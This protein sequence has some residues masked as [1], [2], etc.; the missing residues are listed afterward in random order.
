MKSFCTLE[1]LVEL[2]FVAACTFKL[3]VKRDGQAD[4]FWR[5]GDWVLT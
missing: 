5:R 4:F 1:R 2:V 3:V